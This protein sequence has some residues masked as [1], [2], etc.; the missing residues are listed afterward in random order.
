M[1]KIFWRASSKRLFLIQCFQTYHHSH[2]T[3]T[4]LVW[5]DGSTFCLL[6]S[7]L[8]IWRELATSK[9]LQRWR[10]H[11]LFIVSNLTIFSMCETYNSVF[12]EERTHLDIWIWSAAHVQGGQ[13]CALDGGHVQRLCVEVILKLN[14][15]EYWIFETLSI[16]IWIKVNTAQYKIVN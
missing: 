15:Q 5:M 9:T 8:I 11:N 16:I 1:A 2:I 14:K 6:L 10:V 3:P 7:P 13:L 4:P 12:R